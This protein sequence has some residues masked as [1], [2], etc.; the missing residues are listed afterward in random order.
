MSRSSAARLVLL[1]GTLWAGSAVAQPFI[2]A[3]RGWRSDPA[4]ATELAA[5]ANEVSHF[6]GASALATA[7]V[8]VAPSAPAVLYVTVVAAKIPS[9]REAAVRVEVDSFHGSPARAQLASSNVLVDQWEER[10]DTDAN[11]VRA[12]LQWRD[13]D[14]KTATRAVLVIAADASNVVAVTAECLSGAGVGAADLTACTQALETVD[15]GIARDA[16]V[17]LGLAPVGT[18]PP[19]GPDA[20]GPK[21]GMRPPATMGDGSRAPLPPIT[22]QQAPPPPTDRRPVIVGLGIIV[23]AALFWWNRRRRD[24]FDEEEHDD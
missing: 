17:T 14:A 18:E 8:F 10:V 19:P 3:P 6:G 20:T 1:A 13:D 12:Q 9:A 7:E 16:R 4:R 11:T 23:L 22:V 2:T 15:P 21:P 5:K 24:R